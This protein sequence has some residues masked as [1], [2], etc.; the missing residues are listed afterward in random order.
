MKT[1]AKP[2]LKLKLQ[3]IKIALA[4]SLILN[5][6]SVYAQEAPYEPDV[7][8]E[9][10]QWFNALSDMPVWVFNVDEFPDWFYT[11]ESEPVWFRQVNR[12]PAWFFTIEE[13]PE[14]FYH[15]EE[16]ET[17]PDI[18]MP[19]E[20]DNT[21]PPPIEII[22]PVI[23]SPAVAPP[24]D[25]EPSIP[26]MNFP[27]D[28]DL[29]DYYREFNDDYWETDFNNTQRFF[30]VSPGLSSDEGRFTVSVP[31]GFT[32]SQDVQFSGLLEDY[33]ITRNGETLEWFGGFLSEQGEYAIYYAD[34]PEEPLYTFSI[35]KHA[36]NVLEYS[37]PDGFAIRSV[38]Y[39]GESLVL[40]NNKTFTAQAQDEGEYVITVAQLSAADSPL[41]WENTFVLKT[42][43]PVVLFD[44]LGENMTSEGTVLFW[45]EQEGVALR[46]ERDGVIIN[47]TGT[48]SEPGR[49]TLT[50]TDAAGNSTV[51][52][53][54]IFYTMDVPAVWAIII[55]VLLI[56][57]VAG[58]VF[59]CRKKTRVR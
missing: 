25:S 3:A 36:V 57:S 43:P 50:A 2:R 15:T 35:I 53:F 1:K 51:Y 46:L 5:G 52:S 17:E 59:Y 6:F 33:M 21:P 40:N 26:A 9:F 44:G 45:S 27:D 4:V 11:L 39:N 18:I 29:L 12:I 28:L 14:W 10:P 49:Y 54:R 55:T 48:V 47:T 38:S 22:A 37:V 31:N 58:Y 41:T 42:T 16:E 20:E 8:R 34:N 32:T 19:P 23:I 13:I 24:F 7:L 56:A 30:P